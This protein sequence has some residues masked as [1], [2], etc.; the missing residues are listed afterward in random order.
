MGY[1]SLAAVVASTKIY[2]FAEFE[3]EFSLISYISD[4]SIAMHE[5]NG[6]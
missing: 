5:D 4:S 3:I 1:N 6:L 2:D